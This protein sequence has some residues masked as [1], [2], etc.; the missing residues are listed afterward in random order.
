[1][2]LKKFLRK[3]V[4]CVV[5]LTIHQAFFAFN[6][7]TNSGLSNN[8]IHTLFLDS[9]G[10]LWI[11]T[12]TGLDR[13]DGVEVVPY[14][15]RFSQALKGAV[16]SILEVSP[17]HL[18]I[19]SSWGAFA[20]DIKANQIR[21]FS[22]DI[23][24]IDVK[25][26]LAG[27]DGDIHFITDH[28]HYQ[29]SKA[30]L[31][32]EQMIPTMVDDKNYVCAVLHQQQE[33]I[34]FSR[35]SLK[36]YSSE[37]LPR[38]KKLNI[39]EV[40]SAISV[41]DVVYIGTE[42]GLYS[43]HPKLNKLEQITASIGL[44]IKSLI[45][46][47]DEVLYI[48]TENNSIYQYNITSKNLFAFSDFHADNQL[49]KQENICSML[50]EH[51][52]LYVGTF[53]HGVELLPVHLT[54][55]FNQIDLSNTLDANIR[56][57]HFTADGFR[58][59]GTRDGKFI[60]FDASDKIQYTLAHL[61]EGS[62]IT[63]IDT[64]PSDANILLIG[65]FG[66]GAWLFNRHQRTAQRL[67]NHQVLHHSRVYKFG[68]DSDG[69]LWIAT[70]EG[71]YQYQFATDILTHHDISSVT[72]SNEFFS[73]A[74]DTHN[75]LW[76]GSKTGV[77]FYDLDT[78]VFEQPE[79][80]K[81]Y[82]F[83]CTSIY[84]DRSGNI[85]FTFNKG[86][87]LK[88]DEHLSTQ[89]WLTEELYIPEN[90]PS[91]LIEDMDGRIWI[92][93]SKGLFMVS[94]TNSIHHYGEEDGLKGV[95]IC[96]ESAHIDNQGILWWINEYGLV[97]LEGNL[98]GYNQYSPPAR[99]VGVSINEYFFSTDTLQNFT[100]IDDQHYKLIIKG[101]YNNHLSFSVNSAN[102]LF[103]HKNRFLY[104][105]VGKDTTFQVLTPEPNMLTLDKL[106]PGNYCLEI[107]AINNEGIQT[108]KPTMIQ[109]SIVPYFYETIWF[110]SIAVI[111]VLSLI[112]YFNWN[113]IRAT[114]K[115]EI[116]AQQA[117]R[118]KQRAAV[119]KIDEEKARNILDKLQKWMETEAAYFQQDL[120]QADVAIA[121][122]CTIHELSQTLNT[123]LNQSF[124]DY[125]NRF[126]VEAFIHKISLPESSKYTQTAVAMQ[127]G[128]NSKSS[129]LRAFKKVTGMTPSEY[130]QQQ[131]I[132]IKSE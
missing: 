30:D 75:R 24:G 115:K 86:G 40:K 113:Y 122:D 98:G 112:I 54:N 7:N 132:D 111:F 33:L 110:I 96:P 102:Y 121:L 57:Q 39:P 49:A 37:E 10:F 36:V 87:V 23:P 19:G 74:F 53:N 62:V 5:L 82:Q 31:Y 28:G 84:A 14:A 97:S 90:A 2:L 107:I 61:F 52:M 78:Q 93:S 58:Y 125:V 71:L 17:D 69:S 45:N 119:I 38:E 63:T 101:R 120:R 118:K 116:A 129:F 9:K 128:F 47:K 18:I 43:Y 131:G 26:V 6:L 124:P 89:M 48:G 34:V 108:E 79:N 16:Q 42:N 104:R 80:L 100:Q 3:W 13:Y 20:Y 12:E 95:N 21:N 117:I 8:Y 106:S 60:C 126:R 27:A 83:Q 130:L 44:A 1:M 50:F 22:F 25:Q 15:K 67:G 85:W 4:L 64:H 105:M 66:N 109:F 29:L 56:S 65:T 68:S 81:Q 32:Q 41:A 35:H 103:P 76:I 127:C 72:G 94:S 99:I 123:V 73:I 11:G 92:G 91:S 51:D 77:C 59:A 55:K 46:N 114:V 70:L 88:I